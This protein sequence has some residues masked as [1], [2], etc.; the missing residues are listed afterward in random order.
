MC[1]RGK[2]PY[3][4]G[5]GAGTYIGGGGGGEGCTYMCERGERSYTTGGGT[6]TYTG[7]GTYIGGGGG[8]GAYMPGTLPTPTDT[9]GEPAFTDQYTSRA[10]APPAST[11]AKGS[12]HNSLCDFIFPLLSGHQ[13]ASLTQS[14]HTR[15]AQAQQPCQGVARQTRRQSWLPP[16]IATTCSPHNLFV[17]IEKANHQKQKKYQ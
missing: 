1:E 3:T 9:P 12:A 15:A 16:D 7:A 10:C 14:A 5:G 13:P 6:G 8:G 11:K 17:Q 2:R 4:G